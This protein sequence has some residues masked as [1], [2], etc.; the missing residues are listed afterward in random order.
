[1]A[2]T[3]AKSDVDNLNVRIVVRGMASRSYPDQG[4]FDEAAVSE[5]LSELV[6]Q[7][8]V[9]KEALNLGMSK[10]NAYGIPETEMVLV[11]AF[12]LVKA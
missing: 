2:T 10:G 11:L 5:H 3:K 1:M 9:L 8:Y 12:V 7:G 4:V 6:D